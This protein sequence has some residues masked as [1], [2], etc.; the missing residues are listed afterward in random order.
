MNEVAQGQQRMF[1][2]AGGVEIVPAE[3]SRE[4]PAI[5]ID[6]LIGYGLTSSPGAQVGRMIQWANDSGAPILAL[7]VPSGL[8]ATTGEARGAVISP[9]WTMT[10]ALPKTG[11]SCAVT[12][13]LYLADIGIPREV[14]RRMNLHYRSSFGSRYWVRLEKVPAGPLQSG[15]N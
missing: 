7:D 9:Q 1:Q 5:I 11:L 4:H 10:L 3:L 14:Y 8:D 6:G 12:G 13:G 2:F 15:A